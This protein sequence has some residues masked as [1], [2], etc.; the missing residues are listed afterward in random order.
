MAAADKWTINKLWD[1]YCQAYPEKKSIKNEKVKFEKH[2]REGI[3][4]KDP[5]ELTV[6]DVD[7]LRTGLQKNGK[8]TTAARVLELLRRTLNFGIKRGH[9]PPMAFKIEVPRLNN[10]KTEDLT[11][12]QLKRLKEVLAEEEDQTAANVMRLVLVSGMRKSEIFKLRWADLD[13]QRGFISL[14]D[15]K[16]GTNQKIPL[17][18]SARAIFGSI[19]RTDPFVFPG[20]GKDGH[21][22]DA[23]RAFER[24]VKA[25]GLPEGFRPLHGLRHV[26]ASMLAS[27]GQVDLYTLQRLLTHKSPMMTQ[28]YAHLRDE[29]LMKA[30]NLAGDIFSKIGEQTDGQ[31]DS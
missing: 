29:A 26:Y 16:G 31:E 27:S 11:P 10:Q 3:G 5:S 2:L 22:E 15:P 21:Q 1:S 25:A 18:E 9:I 23:R 30:S 24:I 14:V 17:N 8:A 4:Q 7:E 20:R 13:F 19:E 12:E 6:E 28:R